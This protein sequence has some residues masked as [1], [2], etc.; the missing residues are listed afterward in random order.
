MIQKRPATA[1]VIRAMIFQFVLIIRDTLPPGTV[2]AALG[3]RETSDATRRSR[4]VF[5]GPA[6]L[7]FALFAC[8]LKLPR[9]Q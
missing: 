7:V 6:P 1:T 9:Y 2:T 3:G 8:L 5:A 4:S